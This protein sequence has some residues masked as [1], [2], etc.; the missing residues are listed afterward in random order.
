MQ[1]LGGRESGTERL[2]QAVEAYRGAL[3]VF[4]VEDLHWHHNKVQNNLQTALSR[5]KARRAEPGSVVT[6]N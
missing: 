4:T 3:E 1:T 2:E 5:L 6:P